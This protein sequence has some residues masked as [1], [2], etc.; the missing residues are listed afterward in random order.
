MAYINSVKWPTNQPTN[1]TGP[2]ITQNPFFSGVLTEKKKK[3]MAAPLAPHRLFCTTCDGLEFI[4]KEELTSTLERLGY[5][6]AT[7]PAPRT[8]QFAFE[9]NDIAGVV[10]VVIYEEDR[11]RLHTALSAMHALRSTEQIC[12]YVHQSDP[13]YKMDDRDELA[14]LASSIGTPLATSWRAAS[15]LWAVSNVPFP[16][17]EE[18]SEDK[19]ALRAL[20]SLDSEDTAFLEG[21]KKVV[22]FRCSGIRHGKGYRTG[23]PKYKSP[24]AERVIGE[25]VVNVMGWRAAMLLFN[26]NVQ[27]V[28]SSNCIT[29]GVNL[30]GANASRLGHDFSNYKRRH[31]NNH[32]ISSLAEKGRERVI[33]QQ[34]V[35]ISAQALRKR[36]LS[37][38][39]YETVAPDVRDLEGPLKQ[40]K[41]KNEIRISKSENSM[42]V[43]IAHAL[44]VLARPSPGDVICDPMAGSGT[45][46]LEAAFVQPD[47][48]IVVGG[49][50]T[51]AECSVTALNISSVA[52]LIVKNGLHETKVNVHAQRTGEPER[53]RVKTEE[54]EAN[55]GG[56]RAV[57][58]SAGTGMCR[59]DAMKL[60]L[61]TASVD[62]VVSDFP[63]GRR[64]VKP[65]KLLPAVMYVYLVFSPIISLA[66]DQRKQQNVNRNAYLRMW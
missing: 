13:I 47:A 45:T 42:S 22:L 66:C 2:L 12:A 39:T 36:L 3:T 30:M 7:V 59:W 18:E 43:P 60:P 11:A 19:T 10:R 65:A 4:V 24:D 29:V 37:G 21:L 34:Q 23:K 64:C 6:A 52:D 61:R 35:E 38:E 14:T 50:F 5:T 17:P 49:D 48:S 44:L 31:R 1:R 26:L 9:E 27:L 33:R 57:L 53:K 63:F 15:M 41:T 32:S 25:E 46:L 20:T 8:Q 55:R 28:L 40:I 16:A 58:C 54:A 51:P 56:D 62:V